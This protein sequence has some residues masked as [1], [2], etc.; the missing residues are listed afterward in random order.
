MVK[1]L[2]ADDHAA[3]RAGLRAILE[4]QPELEVVAEVGDGRAAVAETLRLRPDLAILDVRMP[5]HDGLAAAAEI[6][7]AGLTRVAILMLTTYDDDGYL[8]DALAAGAQGFV[9]KSLPPQELIAAVQAA[10]RGDAYVDPSVLRRLSARLAE[11]VAPV[12]Q[13]RPEP[14]ELKRLTSREREVFEL[15]ADG[16]TNQE[17]GMRLYIGDETVKTHV[18]RIMMKLGLRHRLEAIRYAYT[19]GLL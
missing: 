1:V 11:A 5:E 3:F 8:H 6:R 9:L 17:I 12:A 14:A 16:L 15:V 13:R 10:L 4:T 18:S 2:I 7:A 19:H